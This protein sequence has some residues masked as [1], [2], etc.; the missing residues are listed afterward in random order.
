[1]PVAVGAFAFDEALDRVRQGPSL[2]L[3]ATLATGGCGA[4]AERSLVD[5][6]AEPVAAEH[7]A[8][9]GSGGSISDGTPAGD[10]VSPAA[11][12]G[13]GWTL[14]WSDEFN[15]PN[16]DETVW[17][18]SNY[19]AQA[20]GELEYY[21]SR[22]N[23]EPG[24]NVLIENG[25]LVLEAREE[26]H[27]NRNYTSGKI[28]SKGTKAFQ[29][30]RFEARMKLPAE[31]GLWPAFWLLGS[32]LATVGW[33]NCGEVDLMEE[34]GR[35]PASI[36]GTL[37]HGPTQDIYQTQSYQL[38]LGTFHDDWHVFAVE[39]DAASMRWL[40]DGA[41]FFNVPKGN[42][43]GLA[44]PFDQPFFIIFDLAV[45]GK[46]DNDIAPPPGMPPQRLYVDYVRVYQKG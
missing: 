44:W 41:L 9:D 45:G 12:A 3:A 32:N 4:G 35:Q 22:K 10:E 20:N 6:A 23:S 33:P 21:T 26:S 39:W 27:L 15:G 18:I 14:V 38:A 17:N 37:H 7:A 19:P 2:V 24:A 5:A 16:V 46:F 13:A 42:A 40:V 30:G 1:M 29:Y 31:A 8:D 34:R 36:L 25:S 43:A 11:D 28:D